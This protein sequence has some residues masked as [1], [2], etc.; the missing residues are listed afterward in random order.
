[1]PRSATR[2][3]TVALS[4]TS[5]RAKRVTYRLADS[6]FTEGRPARYRFRHPP[7]SAGPRCCDVTEARVEFD[8]PVG[9]SMSDPNQRPSEHNAPE[10]DQ[11]THIASADWP[12]HGQSEQPQAH[13]TPP[14]PH[15]SPQQPYGAPS[16]PYGA[17]TPSYGA[18]TTTY[19]AP[20]PAG[21]G[22]AGRPGTVTTAVVLAFVTAA[23]NLLIGLLFLFGWMYAATQVPKQTEEGAAAASLVFTVFLFIVGLVF[24]LIAGL[25]MWGGLAALKGRT[26]KIL[27]WISAVAAVW[28]LITA[29]SIITSRGE[30]STVLIAWLCLTLIEILCLALSVVIV[31]L[32]LTQSSKDFFRVRGGMTI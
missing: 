2:R 25:F 3:R 5:R 31:I 7:F 23:I 20:L 28:N 13:G 14:P 19:G 1:M 29:S 4:A 6:A 11:P 12:Q 9:G 15:R 10:S 18:P 27:I 21:Y 24:L 17:P 32:V 26:N 30:P 22:A 8:R 16:P